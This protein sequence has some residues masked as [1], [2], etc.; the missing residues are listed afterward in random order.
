MKYRKIWI[1]LIFSL[2]HINLIYAQDTLFQIEEN[3]NL[4]WYDKVRLRGYAQL[5][6][7]GLIQTNRDLTCEQC[8]RSWGGDGEFFSVGL[9]LYFSAKFILGFIFTFNQILLVHLE[10][11]VFISLKFGTLILMW[12]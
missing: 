2:V 7:N 10:E 4:E 8:D 3:K 9:E 11:D 5:R 6:Y 12:V 1:V